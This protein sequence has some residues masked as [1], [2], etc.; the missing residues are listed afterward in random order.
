MLTSVA[1]ST[2]TLMSTHLIISAEC[3]QMA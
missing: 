2:T 1:Y 3:V